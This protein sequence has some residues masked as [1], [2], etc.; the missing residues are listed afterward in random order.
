MTNFEDKTATRESVLI[1][2]LKLGFRLLLVDLN[3][4][5]NKNVLNISQK[6]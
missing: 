6:K 1:Y 3:L 2:F 4:Q 5:H